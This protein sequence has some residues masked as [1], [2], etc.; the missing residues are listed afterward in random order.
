MAGI[1]RDSSGADEEKGGPLQDVELSDE[2]AKKL[3]A[4]Q[5]SLART[6]LALGE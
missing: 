6:E 4:M 2:D 3:T 5:K 1:K